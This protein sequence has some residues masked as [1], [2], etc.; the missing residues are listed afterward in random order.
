MLHSLTTLKLR[1]TADN[2][3]QNKNVST[4][5]E[6]QA[7]SH[8]ASYWRGLQQHL[9]FTRRSRVCLTTPPSSESQLTINKTPAPPRSE[10]SLLNLNQ[11]VNLFIFI[12]NTILKD[13][14]PLK[15]QNLALQLCLVHF[16]TEIY[17][18]KCRCL[19]HTKEDRNNVGKTTA[20]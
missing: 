5:L 9:L 3:T 7:P 1:L 12:W 2:R 4:D 20:R 16:C 15:H 6:S 14:V 8:R 10:V 18:T 19:I 11:L 13:V 17:G